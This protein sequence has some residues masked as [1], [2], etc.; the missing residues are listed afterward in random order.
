MA[1]SEH[2]EIDASTLTYPEWF[3]LWA[4]NGTKPDS[5]LQESNEWHRRSLGMSQKEKTVVF[6]QGFEA[7][8]ARGFI[9]Q[10]TNADGSLKFDQSNPPQPVWKCVGRIVSRIT[11][12]NP[13]KS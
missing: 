1:T 2:K 12:F 13:I 8:H 4:A 3:F 7:L 5:N 10:D 11:S 6:R 9:V